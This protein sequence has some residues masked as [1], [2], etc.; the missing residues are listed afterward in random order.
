ENRASAAPRSATEATRDPEHDK[1]CMQSNSCE[2]ASY[3]VDGARLLCPL[4]VRPPQPVGEGERPAPRLEQQRLQHR[5][6]KGRKQR[7]ATQN[8]DTD[9]TPAF[10][11]QLVCQST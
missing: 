3:A 10:R 6:A 9:V 4:V 2:P 7:R 1:N 8:G 11:R 5:A